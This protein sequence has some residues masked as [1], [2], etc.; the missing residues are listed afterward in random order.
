MW[1]GEPGSVSCGTL[2]GAAATQMSSA[3]K[4]AGSVYGDLA[5]RPRIRS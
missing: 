3:A 4:Q 5:A 1:L 2:L